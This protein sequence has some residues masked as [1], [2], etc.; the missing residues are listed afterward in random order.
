MFGNLVTRW[1]SDFL[2]FVGSGIITPKRLA[3]RQL[4]L[5]FPISEAF[6]HGWI[7]WISRVEVAW[8]NSTAS[9]P[10]Q[11]IDAASPKSSSGSSGNSLSSDAGSSSSSGEAEPRSASP[12]QAR[13]CGQK[14]KYCCLCSILHLFVLQTYPL[15]FNCIYLHCRIRVLTTS[16]WLGFWGYAISPAYEIKMRWRGKGRTPKKR[17]GSISIVVP[18]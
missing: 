11:D 7:F 6:T 15:T 1:I 2:D 3:K 16:R 8:P 4:C 5:L 10:C 12:V 9:F 14:W 17:D 18:F 13:L